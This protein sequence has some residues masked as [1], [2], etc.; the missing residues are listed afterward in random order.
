VPVAAFD[1]LSG[2][3]T[4]PETMRVRRSGAPLRFID[5]GYPSP[6]PKNGISALCQ[7]LGA[8]HRW[9]PFRSCFHGG[10]QLAAFARTILASRVS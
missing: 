8:D 6:A 5:L 9:S 1:L 10:G 7:Y 3:L 2:A 4:E